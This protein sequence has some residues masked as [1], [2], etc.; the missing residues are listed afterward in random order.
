MDPGST[1]PNRKLAPFRVGDWLADPSR[2]VL[3]RGNEQV[4]IEPKTM[5]VLLLLASRAGEVV[6]QAELEAQVWRGLVVTSQSVYQS[7]GQLRRVL[8]DSARTSQYIETV[9]R[10]GYRLVAPVTWPITGPAGTTHAPVESPPA[11]ASGAARQRRF[12]AWPIRL[13]SILGLVGLVMAGWHYWPSQ[14]SD[15][16]RSVAVLAFDDLSDDGSQEYLA[17]LLVE[18]LT[19]ALGQVEGLKVVA[20]HSVRVATR[21]GT[22][23]VEIGERLGVQHVLRGS[24]RRVG[25]RIRVLAVLVETGTGYEEW[26]RT[27]ER[28]A[29]SMSRLP[30]DIAEAV[31]GAI[32]LVLV[33][34]PGVRGSRVGTRNPTAYDYYML[35]Q[36]RFNERTAFALAEAQRYFQLAIEAD[37]AFAAAYVALADVHVAEFYFANRQLSETLDLVQPL[38]AEALRLDSDFGPAHAMLGWAAVERGDR[39]R[40]RAELVRAIELSPNDAKARMWLGNAYFS[41]AK[42]RE[43]LDELDRALELD[44]LN[45]IIHIRRAL[46]LDALG[47]NEAAVEAATRAVTLAPRHPNPHWT[48]ALIAT[49]RG[50]LPGAIA[51][52]EAALALDPARSDLRVQMATL[53][54][55][56]GRDPEARRELAEA[57]RLAENSH[58]YLTARAYEALLDGDRRELAAVAESL[59]SIDPR[60]QYY[61]MDAA[62]F[63]VLAGRHEQAIE[64]F[65]RAMGDN[66]EGVLND[67]WMIRWG[68][69]TAP[70]CLA[71]SYAAVGRS[72]DRELLAR[73]FDSF[74]AE[75]RSQGIRYWGISYQRAA[76]AALAGDPTSAMASLEEASTLGWRRAWWA[77]T[78]PAL[79]SLRSDQQF[80]LLLQRIAAQAGSR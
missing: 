3:V 44:P 19:S 34:D 71:S 43:A 20:R 51:H 72:A 53:L 47:Q 61:M 23:V 17:N 2:D 13:A 73:R 6:S 80:D 63:M 26:T 39:A 8:G 60:N 52:Y 59:A 5:A 24:V 38:V 41:D 37:P 22:G 54:L 79:T 62:N 65:E 35:G 1:I 56:I 7:I 75:A 58:S 66:P 12:Q 69:E 33:G 64:L 15:R 40:A 46:V 9:P 45:F 42:P 21:D 77:R 25:E 57:A 78:D 28:P 48:L 31:A 29:A 30:A 50:D 4:K 10:R 67:L 68:M 11:A 18:E 14:L 36:L 76:M 74:L 55:D 16:P 70:A 32:G 27:F 49:S